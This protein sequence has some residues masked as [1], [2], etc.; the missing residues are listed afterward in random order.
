[1]AHPLL[2]PLLLLLVASCRAASDSGGA[3]FAEELVGGHDAIALL[4]LDAARLPLPGVPAISSAQQQGLSPERLKELLLRDP[5]LRVSTENRRLAFVC[6]SLLHQA[7]LNH[8]WASQQAHDQAGRHLHWHGRGDHGGRSRTLQQLLQAD[9][10][11]PAPASVPVNAAGL[12]LLH[13]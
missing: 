4:G 10:E 13:R 6:G 8:Y 9:L 5:D 11:D 2:L 1:M 12:P 7:A 3:A